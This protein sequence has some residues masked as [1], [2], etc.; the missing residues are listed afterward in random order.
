MLANQHGYVAENSMGDLY[1]FIRLRGINMA[2]FSMQDV[3]M[4]ISEQRKYFFS[5]ATKKIDFRKE[6]LKKLK[7]TISLYEKEIM[8]A[9]HDDLRKSEFEAYSTEVGLVL[10]SISYMQKYLEEWMHPVA[11]STPIHFQPAK[12][13]IV[14]E[15]YGVTLIIGPYNYPFQLV[16]EPLVGAI[17]GG[18]TAIVKPS[19]SAPNTTAIIKKIIQETFEENYIRI[20]EGEVEETTALIHSSFDYVFFTGSVA[21][22]KIVASACAERLTPYTLEL[23]GKSP[24]IVDQTANIEVAVKR[25]VWGKFTNAGQTCVAPDYVLVHESVKVPFIRH[26]KKTLQRFYGKNPQESPD[27]GRII[28]TKQ[29]DRLKSLLDQEQAHILFGG[30]TDREDLYIEPTVLEDIVWGSPIM[31]DEIFGPIMPILVYDDLRQVIHQ[32]RQ[33]PKPLAAYFFS[34]TDKAI[35]YFLDELPFGGGCINDTITHV[36]S[37]H[38]PFGGIGPSGVHNYH[39]KASFECFTHPKSILKKSTK[40]SNNLLFPPYKQKVKLVKTILR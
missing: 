7:A 13:F 5:G 28:N 39:G 16:I 32:I 1:F 24:A 8:Q 26:L 6:Q 23:G 35:Q 10:D 22:G 25:I 4:M 37:V 19:E 3:E 17:I 2:K 21:V 36:A 14:R 29:F 34:E 40:F 30:H 31:E 27:F 12:S 33:K 18:N 9:L 15:P 11:V 20:V 38:L